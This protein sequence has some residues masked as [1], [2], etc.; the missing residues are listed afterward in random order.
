MSNCLNN[1]GKVVNTTAGKKLLYNQNGLVFLDSINKEDD[2]FIKT[3]QAGEFF[4]IYTDQND[5]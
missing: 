4:W 1:A 2:E 3:M 5:I